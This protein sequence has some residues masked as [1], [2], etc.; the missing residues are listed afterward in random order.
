MPNKVKHDLEVIVPSSRA[1]FRGGLDN[2]VDAA[3]RSGGAVRSDKSKTRGDRKVR[4][5][6]QNKKMELS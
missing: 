6:R 4:A 3:P 5:T 2:P 1:F